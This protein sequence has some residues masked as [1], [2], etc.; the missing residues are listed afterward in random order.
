M[1]REREGGET[2]RERDRKGEGGETKRERV[3]KREGKSKRVGERAH[4][5]QDNCC[6]LNNCS[7]YLEE[8]RRR[9]RRR[10]ALL[11]LQQSLF[12]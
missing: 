2:K 7:R 10:K 9:R 4:G 5:R 11:G 12:S 8:W 3:R 6:R 1:K